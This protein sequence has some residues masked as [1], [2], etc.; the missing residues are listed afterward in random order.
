VIEKYTD[1]MASLFRM[2]LQFDKC[3]YDWKQVCDVDWIVD[4]QFVHYSN[5]A[6]NSVQ[7]SIHD[8]GEYY[9]NYITTCVI[10]ND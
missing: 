4:L 9:T 5:E 3:E 6:A 8:L 1:W 2:T 7:L 10:L